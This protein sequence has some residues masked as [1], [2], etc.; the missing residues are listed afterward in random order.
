MNALLHFL[1]ACGLA[2]SCAAT[3]QVVPASPAAGDGTLEP[4][5]ERYDT[6]RGALR[7]FYDMRGSDLRLERLDDFDRG[8]LAELE[9]VEFDALD[10]SGRVD[11][12][13]LRTEIEYGIAQRELERARRG[14]AAELLPFAAAIQHLESERWSVAPLDAGVAAEALA[15]IAAEAEAVQGRAVK[16]ATEEG[17][18]DTEPDADA[19]PLSPVEAQRVAGWVS[20]LRGTLGTWYEHYDAFDPGFSWWCE[21]P[22]GAAREAL[23]SLAEHLRED[24]A[25]LEGEDDDPLVGD[26]IGR[27]ALE[28]DLR[29]E[30]LAYSS[31]ELI[32][33]GRRQLAWCDAELLRAAGEMGHE[34]DW[35][36]ALEEVKQRHVA[37]GEQDELVAA[38]A[39][40][41]IEFLEARDLVSIPPLCAETWR[42]KMLSRE[43]QRTLPF[44]AYGGQK[45]LV[46]FPTRD[47]DHESKLMSLRGNNEHFTRCVTP[48]E[49]IPGH[50]LQ[51]FMAQRYATHRGLFR[52]PFLV[53]GWALYWEM[54]EWDEGWTRGPEDRIGML[55]WRKHRAAR[56]V[57]SLR[58]HLGEMSPDEMIDFLV[59]EVGHERDSATS[60]VRRY[61]GGG[62]SPLYQCGYMIGGLQ[63]RA[64]AREV[65]GG[66][67]MTAKEYHDAVLRLGPIPIE[68]IRAEL[69]GI[70]LGRD[71]GPSWRPGL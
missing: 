60:E 43:G 44:A 69:L 37:P 57:V 41:A 10:A 6:D 36:A 65:V 47:M 64:L 17:V 2:S 11:H 7:S 34:G 3:A 14:A 63:L 35:R 70:E 22:Y 48:H 15:G 4:T 31:E 24:L 27:A 16:A 53:E 13:L 45:M 23:D 42:V 58:F 21:E 54:V 61:I 9:R 5:V 67:R 46:A 25:G 49:L 39:R 19:L 30:W 26:P 62:Y 18:E 50:H 55:F 52:T 1:T 56:I 59:D 66:G 38:Q 51:G 33:V 28:L 40:E 32:E 8:W 20:D 68:M 71:A 29:H 12:L